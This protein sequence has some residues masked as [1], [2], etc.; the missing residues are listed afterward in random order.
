MQIRHFGAGTEP[1]PQQ[2]RT[3]E[4]VRDRRWSPDGNLPG[5]LAARPRTPREGAGASAVAESGA[6]AFV[7]LAE[8]ALSVESS[9]LLQA[10]RLALTGSVQLTDG[11]T[12]AHAGAF[13]L[14]GSVQ[15]RAASSG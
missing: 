10:V 6:V 12:A 11:A 7:A 5:K 1:E 2:I 9:V 8:V 15:L 13:A 14:A 3:I 4:C